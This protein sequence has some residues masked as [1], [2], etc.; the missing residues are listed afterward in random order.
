M[1]G[2]KPRALRVVERKGFL[3]YDAAGAH[4]SAAS[5]RPI[6]TEVALT[7][8]AADRVCGTV[9]RGSKL[10]AAASRVE[11]EDARVEHPPGMAEQSCWAGRIRVT[12]QPSNSIDEPVVH[13]D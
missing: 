10:S 13:R 5:T 12:F 3:G 1:R 9:A 11:S 8:I 4:C 6:D 7:T 2:T